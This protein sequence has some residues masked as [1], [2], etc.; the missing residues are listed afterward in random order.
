MKRILMIL[1]II[2]SLSLLIWFL[3]YCI[4]NKNPNSIIIGL[5]LL[6]IIISTFINRIKCG[7]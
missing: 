1:N 7:Y 3:M 6:S 4:I 5:F 2:V